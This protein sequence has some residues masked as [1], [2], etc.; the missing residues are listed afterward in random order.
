MVSN[1]L[2]LRLRLLPN[3]IIVL[4]S[5]IG[6][7]PSRAST[8][9]NITAS[10]GIKFQHIDEQSSGAI[11]CEFQIDGRRLS[12]SVDMFC[13][14][15]LR[16]QKDMLYL[17]CTYEVRVPGAH[18]EVSLKPYPWVNICTNNMQQNY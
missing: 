5:V 3:C 11:F 2:R 17:A 4:S 16:E 1:S 6:H 18:L 10:R 9:S 8:P 14:R 15:A 13:P 7:L 12:L